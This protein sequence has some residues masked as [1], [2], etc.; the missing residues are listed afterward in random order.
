[1]SR[2]LTIHKW[3]SGKFLINL[4]NDYVGKVLALF[5]RLIITTLRKKMDIEKADAR[6][7]QKDFWI[8]SKKPYY[9]RWVW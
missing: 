1:M 5:I 6:Q 3:K 2:G 4:Q 9:Y 7:I 8:A